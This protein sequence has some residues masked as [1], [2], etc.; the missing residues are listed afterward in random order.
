MAVGV[1]TCSTTW[2]HVVCD[3]YHVRLHTSTVAYFNGFWMFTRFFI[4]SNVYMITSHPILLCQAVCELWLAPVGRWLHGFLSGTLAASNIRRLCER[5]IRLYALYSS[6][7]A[8]SLFIDESEYCYGLSC[9]PIQQICQ[10]SWG[11]DKRRIS[12]NFN[13]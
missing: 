12:Q 2:M 8:P 4:H 5:L 3:D 7:L 13:C 9:W 1:K 10:L 6:I 11:N